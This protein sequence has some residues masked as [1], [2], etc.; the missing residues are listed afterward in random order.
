RDVYLLHGLP[1][2]IVSDRDTRFTDGQTE[3][4]NRSLGNLLRSLV[5][6][7][8]KAWDQKLP[9]A[10]FAHNHAVNRSTGL[11]PNH[12]LAQV[13]QTTHAHLV[14]ATT[15]ADQKRRAVNF[16]VGDFVWAILTKD[17]FPAH[18]YSKLASKKIDLVEIVGEDQS[19]CL[20]FE[21]SQPCSYL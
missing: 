15:K 19:K 4:V 6:D 8:P 9:Q 20:S 18:E 1:A 14:A 21:P 10:E 17:R 16:G 7:H 11:S 13:H 12:V 2:S 3:V 5:G